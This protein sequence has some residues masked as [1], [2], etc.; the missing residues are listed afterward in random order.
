M[1]IVKRP[2]QIFRKDRVRS[3]KLTVIFI[4]NYFVKNKNLTLFFVNLFLREPKAVGKC[5]RGQGGL[6]VI[7]QSRP[8]AGR[9]GCLAGGHVGVVREFQQLLPN[10]VTDVTTP[11]DG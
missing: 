6:I 2:G 1:Q 5:S 9:P 3:L 8:R 11:V 10:D 7:R 4:K